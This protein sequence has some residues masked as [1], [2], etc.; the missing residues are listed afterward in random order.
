MKEA[1]E[2]AYLEAEKV[3]PWFVARRELFTAFLEKSTHRRILDAGCGSGMFLEHLRIRGYTEV[4]GY[5]PSAA[6]RE[7]GAEREGIPIFPHFPEKVYDTIVMLDVLEHVEDD[8]GL[9]RTAFE[10]LGPGGLFC[11]SVPAHPALW[12]SHDEVNMHRRRYTKSGL[13]R[14][15]EEAG[16]RIERLSCWNMFFFLPVALR[17]LLLKGTGSGELGSPG[18]LSGALALT[19]L[20]VENALLRVIDL[21]LGL[22]L[23]AV[24]G[25]PDVREE[26]GGPSGETG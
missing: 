1:Y 26:A 21:P 19:V 2:R 4:E 22:S 9:V 11:L 3:H 23:I 16:F 15:L 14:L 5:E 18:P 10:R 6:L 25:K 17:R 20:R 12:S 7:A 13:R 8:G 24:A